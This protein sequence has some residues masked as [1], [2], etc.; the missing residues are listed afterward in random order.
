M[1]S[2]GE[3]RLR[4]LIKCLIH[5]SYELLTLKASFRPLL[6][7]F[8]TAEKNKT[9]RRPSY[10]FGSKEFV[11]FV[12]VIAFVVQ[13]FIVSRLVSVLSFWKRFDDER[14]EE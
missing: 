12:S 13:S 14:A 7:I 3:G 2:D 4:Q 5:L 6:P 8:I 11:Q 10:F 9:S 1:C